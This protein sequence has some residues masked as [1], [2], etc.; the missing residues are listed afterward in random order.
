MRALVVNTSDESTTVHETPGP[1]PGLKEILL[2][3][4][5]AALNHAV[6]MNAAM[7]LAAQE[8]R[9]LGSD[10]AVQ[11]IQVGEDLA[12]MEGPRTKTGSRVSRFLHGGK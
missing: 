1:K 3:V 9:V 4:R 10:F 7:P 6:Y 12:D 11:V 5:A 2:R 8:N